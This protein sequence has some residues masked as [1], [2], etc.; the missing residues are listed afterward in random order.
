VTI[1]ALLD[2]PPALDTYARIPISFEVAEL[3]DAHDLAGMPAL[4]RMTVRAAPTPF[5]KDY[6]ALDLSRCATFSARD[7]EKRIGAAAVEKR[8]NLGVL[9]DIR[10]APDARRR[11]AGAMLLIA[12]E[13]WANQQGVSWLEVETQNINLPAYKFYLKHGFTVTDVRAHA[14]PELPD[15]V[16][17][18]LHKRLPGPHRVPDTIR[19]PRLVLRRWRSSEAPELK[20]A[21][22]ANLAHLQRWMPWAMAEPSPFD[23]VLQRTDKLESQFDNGLEWLFAIRSHE[24]GEVL[25]GTGLHPRIGPKGLE[26][27]YWLAENATGKGYA[28]EAAE[29]LTRVA[30]EQPGV[31][32]VQIRCDPGNAPSAAIPRR[33]G[34]RH[35]LT[36]EN[37][38]FA[39]TGS[40]RDTMVWQ[41]N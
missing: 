18:L 33:L 1:T 2:S 11:G 26:I 19:T 30:L 23:A 6:P 25:G 31:T 36:I 8:D 40:L 16:Q 4:R 7:G 28:T 39:P 15:E 24:S 14:Y 13:E 32:H 35:V 9:W 27:G 3:F 5:V 17:L 29:A 22:D 41:T 37:E 20:A 12:I 38:P 34:Y 10:V 21:I